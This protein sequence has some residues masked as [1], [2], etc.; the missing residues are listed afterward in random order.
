MGPRS[1]V[2]RKFIF[3]YF[4]YTVII[5]QPSFKLQDRRPCWVTNAFRVA[6]CRKVAPTISSFSWNR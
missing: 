4:R 5:M 1:A 3:L 6:G 2:T